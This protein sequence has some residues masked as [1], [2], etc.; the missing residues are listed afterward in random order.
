M[1]CPSDRNRRLRRR[2]FAPE[3]T[4]LAPPRRPPYIREMDTPV[5][6]PSEPTETEAERRSRLAWEAEAIEEAERSFE[7]E[8]G[9]PFEE[10]EAWVKSWGTP[11]ELPRPRPRKDEVWRRMMR[12]RARQ[13]AKAGPI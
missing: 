7:K 2:S 10:V 8:G 13:K 11:N 1:D 9:I 3:Q 4:C 6:H 12:A 5:P